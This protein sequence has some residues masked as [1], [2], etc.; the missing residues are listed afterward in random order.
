M[1]KDDLYISPTVIR[2]VSLNDPIMQEEIFGPVLPILTY[3]TVEEA[4]NLVNEREKPLALYVFSK[5]KK[6]IKHI[7]TNTS[8]GGFTSNDTMTH[9]AVN[10]LP[11]GGVGPSGIGGYHGKH[12]FEAFSH[13]KPCLHKYPALE[14]LNDVRMPPYTPKKLNTLCWFIGYPKTL[15][16]SH[17]FS[18]ILKFF[19]IGF[20]VAVLAFLAKSFAK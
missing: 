16:P 7:Q 20:V 19:G 9:A 5:D 8:S 18:R 4:I 13:I 2:N 17:T 11:F 10:T 3:K 14:S 12:S 1:D 15:T 6:F